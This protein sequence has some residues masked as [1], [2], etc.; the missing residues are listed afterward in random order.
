MVKPH[1]PMHLPGLRRASAQDLE[2]IDLRRSNE[3]AEKRLKRMEEEIL[4]DFRPSPVAPHKGKA[5][6]DVLWGFLESKERH[7]Y[8]TIELNICLISIDYRA[9]MFYSVFQS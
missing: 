1:F 7:G 6:K 9:S 5:H 8:S 4:G 3:T 2:L